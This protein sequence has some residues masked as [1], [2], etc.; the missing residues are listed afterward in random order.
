MLSERV[1]S[2]GDAGRATG[3]L[4]INFGR[5]S[6]MKF[7]DEPGRPLESQLNDLLCRVHRELASSRYRRQVDRV[8]KTRE[9]SAEAE[10][11]R[12]RAAAAELER[13]SQLVVEANAWRQADAI[14]AYIAHITSTIAASR[15]PAGPELSAWLIWAA[16][17][18]ERLDPTQNPLK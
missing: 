10:R 15:R 8:R 2:R 16:A 17:V 9:R 6:R 12:A 3:A 13:E 1:T 18:A 7:E 4:R 14:R 5:E 11:A